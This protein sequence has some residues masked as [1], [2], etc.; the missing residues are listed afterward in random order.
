[1]LCCTGVGYGIAGSRWYEY[2]NEE[3][4]WVNSSV[5]PDRHKP[6]SAYQDYI[7]AT[8]AIHGIKTLSALHKNF[9]VGI[10]FKLPHLLVHFPH[11]YLE[12]YRSRKGVWEKTSPA[13]LQFPPT[14]HAISYRCCAAPTYQYM[15]QEGDAPFVR[16]KEGITGLQTATP[17][18]MHVELIWAYSASITFLDVQL[19]RVL[20]ALDELNLWNNITIVLTAD[21]GMHN[22]EKGIW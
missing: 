2:Q 13:A 14:A 18:D 21:H 11:K 16:V 15:N 12:M 10:G 5:N 22:G 7:F 8:K 20:D 19:G 1:M 3:W 4:S 6:E 9:F 17:L